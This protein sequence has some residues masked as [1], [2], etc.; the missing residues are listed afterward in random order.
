M[1]IRKT[2]LKALIF[3][4]KFIFLQKVT[5]EETQ[6]PQPLTV[7]SILSVFHVCN[8]FELYF[9]VLRPLICRLSLN[10]ANYFTVTTSDSVSLQLSITSV[11]SLVFILCFSLQ[12]MQHLLLHI[13][14]TPPAYMLICAFCYTALL[15]LT[16]SCI[17]FCHSF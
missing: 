9:F 8:A 5:G 6:T 12:C 16:C 11:K 7:T 14:T 4:Q 17:I 10:P 3:Y 15:S 13:S 2:Q 1:H